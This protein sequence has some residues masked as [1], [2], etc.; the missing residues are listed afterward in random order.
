M[1]FLRP[2]VSMTIISFHKFITL[3]FALKWH[4]FLYTPFWVSKNTSEIL[5]WLMQHT[6]FRSM[7]FNHIE[8]SFNWNLFLIILHLTLLGIW[9]C[10]VAH[11]LT[12]NLIFFSPL[13]PWRGIPF[14][15]I[16][17]TIAC[18]LATQDVKKLL[19]R[20]TCTQLYTL[21]WH[22]GTIKFQISDITFWDSTGLYCTFYP[23][24]G[25]SFA[26]VMISSLFCITMSLCDHNCIND[27][28]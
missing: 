2:L 21:A 24:L 11:V 14:T 13:L 16:A 1:H 5:N 6:T 20:T 10:A 27:W 9:V 26:F 17:I 19:H 8:L 4:V 22:T 28:V 23:Y 3:P 7:L 18:H 25:M 12:L 15:F